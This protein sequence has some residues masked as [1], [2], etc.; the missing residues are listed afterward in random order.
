M[1]LI[2]IVGVGAAG[3][4]YRDIVIT[5]WQ[6]VQRV[7]HKPD[8]RVV[9]Q[10]L[11]RQPFGVF[12][13]NNESS[14]ADCYVFDRAGI[15]FDKARTIVGDVIVRLDEVTDRKPTLNAPLID[16]ESWRNLYPLL[17]FVESKNIMV[18]RM[19][20]QRGE[21]EVIVTLSPANIP[22]YVS[23]EFNPSEHLRALKQ[24]EK[25]VALD[26]VQYLDLRVEGKIFYK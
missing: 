13:V 12:C 22:V 18:S 9:L 10:N 6:D 20:L 11:K 7:L 15:V 4:Y 24:L 14:E 21:R 17:V 3:A 23:L 5:Y 2:I 19:L 1:F 25:K 16:G 8:V 26:K